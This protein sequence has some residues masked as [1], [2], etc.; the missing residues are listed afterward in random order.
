MSIKQIPSLLRYYGSFRPFKEPEA[1]VLFKIAAF[2]EAVGWTLLILGI[3]A[4]NVLLDGSGIPVTI[5]GRLHGM[6]VVLY[7]I[8]VLALSPSLRWS[9]WRM[10]VAVAFSVPPYGSLIYEQISA[11]FRSNGQAKQFIHAV[12]YHSLAP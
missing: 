12:R 5:A 4:R 6:V 3:F 8:A 9:F 1:W 2:A 10:L 7:V 11:H